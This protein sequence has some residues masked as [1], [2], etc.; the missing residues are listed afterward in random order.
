MAVMCED[1]HKMPRDERG[2]YRRIRV[3][4]DLCG[5]SDFAERCVLQAALHLLGSLR[6]E[7]YKVSM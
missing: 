7:Q 4:V 1:L 3:I 6:E 5:R 2:K